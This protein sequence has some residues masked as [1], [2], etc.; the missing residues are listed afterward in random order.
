MGDSQIITSKVDCQQLTRL[1]AVNG[2]KTAFFDQSKRMRQRLTSRE[3]V[4]MKKSKLAKF[5]E[6][7][8]K[9]MAR[10]EDVITKNGDYVEQ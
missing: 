5:Y 1:K 10:W 8:R 3:E 7:M 4:E 2:R 6:G 9:L